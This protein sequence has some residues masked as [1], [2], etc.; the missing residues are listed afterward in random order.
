MPV[1][2]PILPAV[3]AW[4]ALRIV[5]LALNNVNEP[6]TVPIFGLRTTKSPAAAEPTYMPV[7]AL[8]TLADV[9]VAAKIKLL[10]LE[11]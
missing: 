5:A 10:E 2:P 9:G 7:A 1:V 4:N 8:N 6:C 3:T 11:S